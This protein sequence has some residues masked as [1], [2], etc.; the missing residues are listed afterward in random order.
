[1][2]EVI[3]IALLGA[4]TIGS[5]VLALLESNCE[6]I[7]RKT[8]AA[9]CVKKVLETNPQTIEAL[10]SKYQIA[11]NLDEILQ[12]ESIQIVIELIG[13][14]EPAHTF[15]LKA[16][17]AGKHVVTANKDVIAKYGAELFAEAEKQ[18][19]SL[20]FEASVGG[21]IPIIR[22]LKQ[23][24]AANKI[25][26]IMGIVNGT[27]NYMLTK[28]TKEKSDYPVVLKEAQ[29]HGYAESDP[30]ADVGG[31][32][33]A[34][35]LVILSSIAFNTRFNIEQVSIEGIE[36]I[37]SS[38]I[39]YAEE[40]GYTIKLLAIAE[41]CDTNGVNLRV[42]PTFLAKSHPLS[43]IN[44]VFNAIFVTGDA[45]DD[46]MF[47]G[48]GAGKMPT[49]SA[50]C[51]DIMDVAH[52]ITYHNTNN[53]VCGCYKNRPVCSTNKMFFSFYI[54][55]LVA[56]KPGVLSAISAA[57]GSQEVSIRSVVQKRLVDDNA[58]L[59]IVTHKVLE[60]N[61]RMAEQTL[62]VMPAVV[63]ICNIIRVEDDLG[64]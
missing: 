59:V 46:V 29:A 20:F 39:E 22:P 32:D 25:Q 30:S 12:D 5:G 2:K 26:K 34:R 18:K 58:E 64:D 49:A 54:R 61:L 21:G 40:F 63:D 10:G 31:L 16:L 23:C 53:F 13:R 51:A 11:A 56:D 24:L 7:A 43:N 8:N 36:R 44:G 9:I 14:E 28:M 41:D 37:S 17:Q 4:G 38:D 57:F 62:K 6:D 35:K 1:M 50:V 55:L 33:A 15:I 60:I 48:R 45:V 27:T 3:N 52:N 47:Y 42:H 19:L